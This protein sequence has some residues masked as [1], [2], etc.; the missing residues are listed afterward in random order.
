MQQRDALTWGITLPIPYFKIQVLQPNDYS[1]RVRFSEWLLQKMIRMPLTTNIFATDAAIFIRNGIINLHYT[2]VWSISSFF[3]CVGRYCQW[4]PNWNI[5]IAKSDGW[6]W[7]FGISS[8]WSAYLSWRFIFI[9][10]VVCAWSGTSTFSIT[11][12]DFLLYGILWIE[13]VGTLAFPPEPLDSN[14]LDFFVW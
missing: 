10:I 6:W 12:K 11:S 1:S 5:H 7:I 13:C 4:S 2:H 14:S 8:S 3:E 9:E